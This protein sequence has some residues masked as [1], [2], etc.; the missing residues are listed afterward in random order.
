MF[1]P[2]SRWPSVVDIEEKLSQVDSS[3]MSPLRILVMRNVTV[4]SIEP[5]YQYFANEIGCHAEV[6][7]GGFDNFVQESLGSSPEIFQGKLD[8]VCVFTPLIALSTTLEAGFTA[9]SADQKELEV[10]RIEG[11]FETVATG[12][13]E[14]TD[15]TIL[16]HGLETPVYPEFGIY[17]SQVRD[18]QHSIITRLNEGLRQVLTGI[19]NAFLVNTDAIRARLGVKQF[20][21][22]R[23]WHLARSPYSRSGLAELAH[24]DFK[25]LRSLK[26][27]V[28]KCLVLDCDNTLWGGV[29]GED[30][31]EGIK[32]G[33][34]S[35]GAAY[36][37]FQ[38]AILSLFHRGVILA[39][40]SKN[41]E[42]DVWEVFEKHPD[43]VLKREHIAAYCIN[44]EDKASNLQSIAQQLNIGVDSLVFADDSEFEI[45]LV[46][47]RL[48]M[49]QVLQL[50]KDRPTEYRWIL[51]ATAPFDQAY[52]TDEDRRRG[53][54]YQAQNSRR[55]ESRSEVDLDTYYRSLEMKLE[56]GFA[57]SLIIP[58]IAQQTQKTNQFNLTTR[59][60]SE[61]DVLRFSASSQHHVLWL[62]L[63][64]KFGDSGIVGTCILEY[65]KTE[66]TIDTLLLSCRALGRDVER[67]FLFEIMR[68]ARKHGAHEVWGQYCESSKNMQVAD[69]YTK[70]NFLPMH[71]E[72]ELGVWFKYD[73]SQ[74]ADVLEGAVADVQVWERAGG[75]HSV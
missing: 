13:R 44:W 9:L 27:C 73:L 39:L 18:G 31:V 64:D 35:P 30:G 23:Y 8:A 58:R 74:L 34:G 3:A 61:A 69:F 14:R 4:E 51:N 49:V 32:L 62:R 45:Y 19:G 33:G 60:Y 11:I 63:M 66:V 72:G 38:R 17:D 5:Y 22:L 10:S 24:E 40:C 28:R 46:R 16:W 7:F 52:L 67:I 26:G 70:N 15:A 37:E 57:N 71:R 48:P 53:A 36:V 59:R 6:V 50:P 47:E 25:F 21:D 2:E 55:Q 56:I 41:N 12:I 43:M 75:G 1:Y 54:M 42:A 20:Y 29:V 65:A 68:I